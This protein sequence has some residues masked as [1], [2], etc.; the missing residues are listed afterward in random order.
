[1]HE[2]ILKEMSLDQPIQTPSSPLKMPR[3]AEW[4]LSWS[5]PG[6]R[7]SE[8]TEITPQLM[9]VLQP[10]QRS[11]LILWSQRPLARQFRPPEPS[12][13]LAGLHNNHAVTQLASI[14]GGG[15]QNLKY[16][17]LILHVFIQHTFY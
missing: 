3:E 9:L 2:A 13:T 6:W 12:R 1:M 10:C 4:D 7:F 17:H 11:L 15:S 14:L 16:F 5:F 8:A